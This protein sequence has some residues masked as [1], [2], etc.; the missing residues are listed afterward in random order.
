[1]LVFSFVVARLVPATHA[2]L[3]QTQKRMGA[4]VNPQHGP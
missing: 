3:R 4:R 2:E 1:M